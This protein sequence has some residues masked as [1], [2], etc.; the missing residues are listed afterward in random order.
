MLFSIRSGSVF[1]V[2]RLLQLNQLLKF[3]GHIQAPLGRP[4]GGVFCQSLLELFLVDVAL[5]VFLESVRDPGY[6][7][8]ALVNELQS[9]LG[10]ASLQHG[11]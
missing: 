5:Q 10:D 3:L 11:R 2:A 4:L 6:L 7:F 1:P 9:E 8:R